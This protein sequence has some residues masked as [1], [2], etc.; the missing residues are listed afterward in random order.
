M[1]TFALVQ[2]LVLGVVLL[3]SLLA[4]WRKLMPKTSTRVLADLSARLN[5]PW[6]A[7]GLRWLGRKLQPGQATGSCGD[8]CGS[9]GACGPTPPESAQMHVQPLHFRPRQRP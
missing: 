5:K 9:C 8:G 6:R 4:A 2:A 7:Q 1:S 3:A